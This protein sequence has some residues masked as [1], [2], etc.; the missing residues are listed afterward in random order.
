MAVQSDC[1]HVATSP[2]ARCSTVKMRTHPDCPHL[3]LAKTV[4]CRR[5]CPASFRRSPIKRQ[6]QFD[7]RLSHRGEHF[8]HGLVGLMLALS[9]RTKSPR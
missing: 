1:L 3:S 6:L 2:P 5:D 4:N 8:G 9:Y 7:H